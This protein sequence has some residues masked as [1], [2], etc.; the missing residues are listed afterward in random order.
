MASIFAKIISGE[1]PSLNI[2]DDEHTLAFMDI[3]P[4]TRE[5]V[6]AVYYDGGSTFACG[7]G[8]W[9]PWLGFSACSTPS[10]A[11]RADSCGSA[12]RGRSARDRG[13]PR[14]SPP[15]S[16]GRPAAGNRRLSLQLGDRR[17]DVAAHR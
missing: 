11:R 13:R 3:S 2:Y 12:D 7:S 17:V 9:P 16:R 5:E 14:S 4:A 8:A 10:R 1:I 15:R 6:Y